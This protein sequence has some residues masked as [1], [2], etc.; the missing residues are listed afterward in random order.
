MTPDEIKAQAKKHAPTAGIVAA[1]VV[2]VGLMM[3]AQPAEHTGLAPELGA[4]IGSDVPRARPSGTSIVTRL[5]SC[6]GRDAHVAG[7]DRHGTIALPAE[8]HGRCTLLFAGP[9]TAQPACMAVGAR[10]AKLTA[11]D[12]VL[13]GA[14]DIVVYDCGPK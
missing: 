6:G 12:L 14:S 10:I 11:T 2:A 8:A 4:S 13:E 3:P 9:W 7:N 1:G 5:V